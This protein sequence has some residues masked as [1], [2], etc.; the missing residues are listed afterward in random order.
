MRGRF[1]IGHAGHQRPDIRNPIAGCRERLARTGQG[2][3]PSD[4]DAKMLLS[5]AF[6]DLVETTG[7]EPVAPCLQSSTGRT[8]CSQ[9]S[10]QVAGER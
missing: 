7:L 5:W 10:S 1:P 8:A 9:A 2:V 6:A 3:K 4:E